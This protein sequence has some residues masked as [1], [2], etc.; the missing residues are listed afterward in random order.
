M[1]TW[2]LILGIAGLG[3]GV[4]VASR[5]S[6]EPRVRL[7]AG[8]LAVGAIVLILYTW[9]LSP[10]GQDRRYQDARNRQR[11]ALG[12]GVGQH[13]KQTQPG[14]RLAFLGGAP[15]PSFNRSFVRGLKDGL[16]GASTVVIERNINMAEAPPDA[17][18]QTA[19]FTTKLLTDLKA[20]G[21]EIVVS[22]AGLP[23]R[24]DEKTE[25]IDPQATLELW[26]SPEY[27]ALQ[28]VLVLITPEPWPAG[29][30]REG[31]VL[32]VVRQKPQTVEPGTPS[33]LVNRRGTPVELF[34]ASFELVT[35]DEGK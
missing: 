6:A 35:S 27:K 16:A 4:V 5:R 12:F 2:Q 30:F 33:D 11:Y 26:R 9:L 13:L 8:L 31:Q 7:V 22:L 29:M 3:L 19:L 34:N 32:A 17:R 1:I 21:A 28:W 18:V 23:V 10:A 14:R 24:V 25:E 20:A 15:N